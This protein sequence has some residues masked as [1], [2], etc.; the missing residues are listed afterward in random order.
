MYCIWYATLPSYATSGFC[1][2]NRT[3]TLNLATSHLVSIQ[4]LGRRALRAVKCNSS[5][6]DRQEDASGR[7]YINQ[8]NGTE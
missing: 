6:Y 5:D 2:T 8:K 3:G 1:S 7:G 4:S